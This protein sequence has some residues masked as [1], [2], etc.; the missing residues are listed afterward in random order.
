MRKIQQRGEIKKACRF[1][2][3]PRREIGRETGFAEE[4]VTRASIGCHQPEARKKE[5]T[6]GE[7]RELTGPPARL[8]A[9]GDGLPSPLQREHHFPPPIHH[10]DSNLPPPRSSIPRQTCRL[11][12]TTT[13]TTATA[14]TAA[15]AAAADRTRRAVLAARTRADDS[16][17]VEDCCTERHERGAWTHGGGVYCSRPASPARILPQ[18]RRWFARCSGA[19][20]R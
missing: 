2:R 14:A 6:E 17:E 19:V 13:A 8:N 1:N 15:R 5:T 11:H 12:S 18:S 7:V 10:S 9:G 4:K 16:E 20:P 3:Q